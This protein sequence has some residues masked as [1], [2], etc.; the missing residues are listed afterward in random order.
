M[1]GKLTVSNNTGGAL[2]I[3]VGIVEQTDVIQFDALSNQPNDPN[4]SASYQNYGAFSFSSG[5]PTSY[6]TS[7]AIEG[8]GVTG[9]GF[10]VGEQVTWTN[11]NP[12]NIIN[13]ATGNN[14]HT[15]YVRYW[16]SANSKLWLD[17]MSHPSGL[18]VTADTT[19]TGASS[20]STISA[21]PSFAG[22]GG[23][24]GWSGNVRFYDSLNGRL[25]LQNHEFKNNLD[26]SVI[27]DTFSS[28]NENREQGNNNL[29]R[30]LGRFYRPVATTQNRFSATGT[31]TPVTEF[32]SQNG[33]ELLV[34]GISKIHAEQYLVQDKS[35][36]DNDIF[37]LSGI[38]LG[39]YQSLYVKSTGAVTFTL[40]GF[41]ETAEIPS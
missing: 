7:I 36:A 8:G 1:S 25:Y 34:S 23:Y 12:I 11:T 2:N 16:D 29:N 15:A 37:E 6:A 41:E 32:I 13:P 33:I 20:G 14:N 21:G 27:Y 9:S 28:P 3:D 5:T 17:R 24:Q 35:V 4:T 18:E 22:S 38:V 40:I 39:T 10:N 19:F 31:T 26:Y 30:S